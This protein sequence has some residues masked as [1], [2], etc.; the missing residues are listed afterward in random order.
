M[1]YSIIYVV[2]GV[3]ITVSLIAGALIYMIDKNADQHEKADGID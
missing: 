1:F 2:A 3:T